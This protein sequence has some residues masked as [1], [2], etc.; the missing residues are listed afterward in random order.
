MLYNRKEAVFH[1]TG[2]LGDMLVMTGAIKYF[3]L[4]HDLLI[5]PIVS[6]HKEIAS[7]LFKDHK[8]IKLLEYKVIDDLN[9]F[10]RNNSYPHTY[11]SHPYYLPSGLIATDITD[12]NYE[13]FTTMIPL[14]DE[15]LYT[16]FNLPFSIRYQYFHWPQVDKQSEELYNRVVERDYILVSDEIRYSPSFIHPLKIPNPNNYQVIRLSP[17]LCSN[18]LYYKKLILDA[19][20]IHCAASSMFCLVDSIAGDLTASLYYHDSRHTPMR[21]NNKWNGH[22]WIIIQYPETKL[23]VMTKNDLL[24]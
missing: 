11:E 21:V 6:R 8:N 7:C 20:E 9:E 13:D 23:K 17:D 10:I 3:S 14:W 16:G 2:H 12:E 19:K 1:P 4:D 15:Q 5:V 18:P 24:H 22:K